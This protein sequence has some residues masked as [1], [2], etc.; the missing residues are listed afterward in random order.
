MQLSRWHIHPHCSV[1]RCMLYVQLIA[2]SP[3]EQGHSYSTTKARLYTQL[4]RRANDGSAELYAS[5]D[6]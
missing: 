5:P 2:P 3:F 1:L 4:N 6:L